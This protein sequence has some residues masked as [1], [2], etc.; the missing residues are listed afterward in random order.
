VRST[1]PKSLLKTPS[2]W[3]KKQANS[4]NLEGGEIMKQKGK[5]LGEA[6]REDTKSHLNVL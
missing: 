2:R 5:P 3:S 1:S 6:S 4:K